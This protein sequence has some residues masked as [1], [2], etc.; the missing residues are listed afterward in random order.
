MPNKLKQLLSF[1]VLPI[2]ITC[3]FVS[4]TGDW[5]YKLPNNYEIVRVNSQSIVFGKN[6]NSFDQTIDR[7][8]LEFCYNE[9]YIGLKRLPLDHVPADEIVDIDSLDRS[10]MEFYLIDAMKDKQY[11]PYTEEQFTQKC[12]EIGTGNLGEWILTSDLEHSK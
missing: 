5:E 6:N 4:C 9:N 10:S 2:F 8:I 11:G 1:V 3:I 12:N 7:Y